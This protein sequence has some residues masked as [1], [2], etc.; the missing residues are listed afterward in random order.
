MLT[1]LTIGATRLKNTEAGQSACS[2]DHEDEEHS[3]VVELDALRFL[4]AFPESTWHQ[5]ATAYSRALPLCASVQ[6]VLTNDIDNVTN[7]LLNL[8]LQNERTETLEDVLPLG[9]L[10]DEPSPAP[11]N[12]DPTDNSC[13]CSRERLP[14]K[15]RRASQSNLSPL[16][17]PSTHPSTPSIVIT[18]SP[19]QRREMSGLVPYQDYAFGRSLTVP[20]H[21]LYN[22]VHP[23]MVR[24][25]RI[26][27]HRSAWKWEDGHWTAVLPS[28]LEQAERGLFSR[29]ILP[30]KKIRRRNR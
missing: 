23:P 10:D 9:L 27:S 26:P 24:D 12:C 14:R 2:T 5:V 18:L 15:R 25:S 29:P 20:C 6:R 13:F 22:K 1:R 17:I 7:L 8:E 3:L 16:I 11:R 28:V 4:F 21:H 30:R 19:P